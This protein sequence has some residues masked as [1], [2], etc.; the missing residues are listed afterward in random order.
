MRSSVTLL[1]KSESEGP[2]NGE[3]TKPHQN[4]SRLGQYITPTQLYQFLTFL[5]TNDDRTITKS[6]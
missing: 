1:V 5:L 6:I 2:Q 4:L 3:T